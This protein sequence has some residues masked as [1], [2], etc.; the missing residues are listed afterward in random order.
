VGRCLEHFAAGRRIDGRLRD[1]GLWLLDLAI[2]GFALWTVLYHLAL[3]VDPPTTGLL[4]AWLACFSVAGA[5]DLRYRAP[6]VSSATGNDA[7]GPG[8]DGE[9]TATRVPVSRMSTWL[10]VIAGVAAAIAVVNGAWL[11]SV[12]LAAVALGGVAWA[13]PWRG[14]TPQAPAGWGGLVALPIAAGFAVLSQFIV[15]P[16]G[17]DTL[18]V[19]RA[20]WIAEHGR[21]PV[22]DTLFGDDGKVLPGAPPVSSIEALVGTLARA[23][24]TSAAGFGYY[25]LLPAATLL[26]ILALWRLIRVWA[27]RSAV[28]CLLLAGAFLLWSGRS[29]ASFGSFQ[30]VRSW[31]GKAIF[32]SLAVPALYA[33]LTEWA[34][35]RS[36]RSFLLAV[37]TGAA[38]VGLTSSATFVVPLVVAAAGVGLFVRGLWQ[39]RRHAAEHPAGGSD[40]TSRD[41][42]R[43]VL[44]RLLLVGL[45]AVYP[46]CAGLAVTTFL[47]G[48]PAG[49][50]PKLNNAQTS[51]AWVVGPGVIGL[52]GGAALWLGPLLVPRGAAAATAFGA[53]LATVAMLI[54]GM[55]ELLADLTGSG[56]VL[57]R[58]LWVAPVPALVG[59]LAAVPL[60]ALG[61]LLSPARG[62]GRGPGWLAGWGPALAAVLALVLA[63]TPIWASTNRARLGSP[64]WKAN[65][66][67]VRNAFAIA[68]GYPA[69][70]RV[71]AP[72]S[73]MSA[74][75]LVTSRTKSVNPRSLYL[76]GI[77]DGTAQPR[78]L[79]T[80]FADRRQP[81]PSPEQVSN[82][83]Q[84]LQVDVVCLSRRDATGLQV[85][86]EAGF[87]DDRS[88]GTN[89]RCLVPGSTPTLN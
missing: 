70:K 6:A 40:T 51:W 8:G 79:L 7:P 72:A 19:N 29:T 31:Q 56:P 28:W 3:I 45:V 57:W 75:P 21:I 30:L 4:I 65:L 52:L 13:A 20:V 12:G 54:P 16:D 43:A 77:T 39:V 33:Y 86:H 68:H 22:G 17:D 76:Q 11:V 37:A 38:G 66:S 58:V 46:V 84:R 23:L 87:G 1:P 88:V 53:A 49:T 34:E 81:A 32:V 35:T 60:T 82:A 71:L 73:V 63:G 42:Y 85:A 47:F 64:Q 69:A 83:L 55:M 2:I 24:N 50:D 62:L 48:A 14:F 61:R 44:G 25:V 10:A 27:P 89:L 5:A 41:S 80:T 18:Y 36:R 59:M 9:P 67:V 15:R 74:L 26:A 78:Q